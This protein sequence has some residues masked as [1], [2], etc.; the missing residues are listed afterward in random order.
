MLQFFFNN[1]LTIMS[2]VK[3][4][5][6]FITILG[7]MLVLNFLGFII[8]SNYITKYLTFEAFLCKLVK[9]MVNCILEYLYKLYF[10][11]NKK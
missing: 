8:E 5:I 10:I 6:L 1:L 9:M 3:H 11:S 2:S 7:V 4:L